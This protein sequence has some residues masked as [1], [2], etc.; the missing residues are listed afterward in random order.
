MARWSQAPKG[1]RPR[2][3]RAP[4]PLPPPLPP[5]TRTVGQLIAETIRLYGKKFWRALPLG[6]PL[7][8]T[9]VLA[10]GRDVDTQTILLWICGPLFAA[11]YVWASSLVTET[12]LS[13]GPAIAALV[14]GLIVFLPFPIGA[15][16]YL[17]PGIVILGMFGLAVPA[18]LVERLDVR[19]ALRRG[20]DLGRVD[21]VHAVGGLAAVCIVYF[22]S[23]GALQ[24]LLHTQG[25]QAARVAIAMADIVLG[26]L[27]FLGGAMLYFDQKA[28]LQ[29][30]RVRES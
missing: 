10:F 23:R 30:Q 6:I 13:R 27:V 21:P 20:F 24:V 18:A 9:D 2:Q 12:P 5:E 3:R 4:E 15:R 8:L 7:A 19:D 14:V 16:V 26:P 28:R 17:L 25:D 11:A 1:A 22:V 29:R